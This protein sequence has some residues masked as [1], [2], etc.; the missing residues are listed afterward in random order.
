LKVEITGNGWCGR[1]F[2]ATG[3]ELKGDSSLSLRIAFS[4]LCSAATGKELKGG[5][6][7]GHRPLNRSAAT[8]KELKGMSSILSVVLKVMQQLGKN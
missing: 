7:R 4:K 1:R 8:G 2:A 5:G 6:L 3:K